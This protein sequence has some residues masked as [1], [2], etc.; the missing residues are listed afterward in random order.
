MRSDCDQKA[1]RELQIGR[2]DA[3]LVLPIA[4]RGQQLGG[5]DSPIPRNPGDALDEAGTS[6]RVDDKCETPD[7]SCAN[8]PYPN[9]LTMGHEVRCHPTAQVSDHKGPAGRQVER[10]VPDW[11]VRMQNRCQPAQG[12]NRHGADPDGSQDCRMRS[13]PNRQRASGRWG[14]KAERHSC[15]RSGL[16]RG[17]RVSG[18]NQ[19][20]LARQQKDE[21]SDAVQPRQSAQPSTLPPSA[22]ETRSPIPRDLAP[23]RSSS[24]GREPW[25]SRVG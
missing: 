22:G 4:L 14:P 17:D 15:F 21:E 5:A 19:G 20:G 7:P 8:N 3:R 24:P 16:A 11:T 12:D 1:T 25:G 10:V 6:C 18:P 23:F 13:L 2:L 9:R